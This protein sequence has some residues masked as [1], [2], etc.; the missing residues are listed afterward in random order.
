MQALVSYFVVL[1]FIFKETVNMIHKSQLYV[2]TSGIR[3]WC[4]N[5]MYLH[6]I[7]GPALELPS[8]EKVWFIIGEEMLYELEGLY[9]VEQQRW[10]PIAMTKVTINK[11]GEF[12]FSLD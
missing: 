5:K 11:D 2:S 8:G 4:D 12:S 7:G 10:F 9:R 3:A 6:R 1:I